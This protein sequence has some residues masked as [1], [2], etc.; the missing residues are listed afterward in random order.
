[1]VAVGLVPELTAKAARLA[2]SSAGAKVVKTYSYEL[3]H[4]GQK[5]RLL[6]LHRLDPCFVVG[7]IGNKEVIIHNA[8]MLTEV[9]GKFA[10]VIA[11]NKAAEEVEAIFKK[12]GRPYVLTENVM[13][14]LMC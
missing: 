14:T 3:T 10:T 9:P 4:R 1:M 6:R 11:G 8:Q 12:S 2:A 13:L 7:R 5:K